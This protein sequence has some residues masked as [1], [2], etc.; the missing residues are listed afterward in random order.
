MIDAI[1]DASIAQSV[2][3]QPCNG[4]NIRIDWTGIKFSCQG[5]IESN[6][7]ECSLIMQEGFLI[8]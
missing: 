3:Q 7:L 1:A 5:S 6:M 8:A 2:E 4:S